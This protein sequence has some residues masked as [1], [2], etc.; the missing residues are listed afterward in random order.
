MDINWLNTI[1]VVS[2]AVVSFALGL[3][4]CI[5]ALIDYKLASVGLRRLKEQEEEDDDE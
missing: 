2:F 1:L 5:E 4:W 3:K